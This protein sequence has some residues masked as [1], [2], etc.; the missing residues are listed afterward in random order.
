MCS[1]DLFLSVKNLLVNKCSPCHFQGGLSAGGTDFDFS[2]ACNIVNKWDRI[3][4]RAVDNIPTPMPDIPLSGAE[5]TIITNW[6][7]GGHSYGN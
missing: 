6:V 5:K 2:L 4:D 7:N 3:K 1:S